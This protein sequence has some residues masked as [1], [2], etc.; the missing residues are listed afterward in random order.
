MPQAFV[1]RL[2]TWVTKKITE[3]LGEEEATFVDFILEKVKA[4][5]AAPSFLVELEPVLDSEAEVFM[6]KL[7]RMLIFEILRKEE[8]DKP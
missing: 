1:T 8:M 2:K 4:H 3:L 7:W 5:V 6:I